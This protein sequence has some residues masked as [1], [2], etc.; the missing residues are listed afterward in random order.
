MGIDYKKFRDAAVLHD[1]KSAD[2]RSDLQVRLD[3]HKASAPDTKLIL[4]IDRLD[5]SKGIAKAYQ[6]V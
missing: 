1:S 4:S 6:C 2:E 5:Y 3:S